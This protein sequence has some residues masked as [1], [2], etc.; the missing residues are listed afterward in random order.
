MKRGIYL[1]ALLAGNQKVATGKAGFPCALLR[2]P[3]FTL[4]SASWR[5]MGITKPTINFGTAAALPPDTARATYQQRASPGD[6]IVLSREEVCLS[7]G[8]T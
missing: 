1:A 8:V 2:F 6:I 3:A 7:L 4:L 5:K